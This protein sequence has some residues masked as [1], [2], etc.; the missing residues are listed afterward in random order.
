MC[1]CPVGAHTGSRSFGW[2]SPSWVTQAGTD[3]AEVS[4]APRWRSGP[5][6]TADDREPT[7]VMCLDLD[8]DASTSANTD[9]DSDGRSDLDHC[10][11]VVT[12]GLRGM[13]TRLQ[14]VGCLDTRSTV[15]LLALTRGLEGQVDIDLSRC[16]FLDAAGVGAL[17]AVARSVRSRGGACTVEGALDGVARLLSLCGAG[18]FLGGDRTVAS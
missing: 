9:T 2:S 6:V 15:G 14:V 13:P 17:I 16:V 10:T 3:R 12:G 5:D 1:R 18:R 8:I 11:F 7:T 4:P